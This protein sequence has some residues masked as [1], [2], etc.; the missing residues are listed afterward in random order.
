MGERLLI[1]K[2]FILVLSLYS[3][4]PFAKWNLISISHYN[5]KGILFLHN[6]QDSSYLRAKLEMYQFLFEY[7][8][9]EGSWGYK[10][11]VWLLQNKFLQRNW[12]YCRGRNRKVTLGCVCFNETGQFWGG[13]RYIFQVCNCFKLE[14][15]KCS[16]SAFERKPCERICKIFWKSYHSW[17]YTE[18][19]ENW[20][21]CEY[22]Q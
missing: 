4:L 20:M 16:G 22:F 3:F 19:W 15:W 10:K 8:I 12:K 13:R 11:W 7:S 17:A 1:F 6:I 18:I 21:N 14:E 5:K 2:S 9:F